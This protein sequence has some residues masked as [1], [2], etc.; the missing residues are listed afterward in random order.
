MKCPVVFIAP[1]LEAASAGTSA[2]LFR[3]PTSP[4]E[5]RAGIA[6]L[7]LLVAGLLFLDEFPD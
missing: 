7:T 1:P 4:G 3:Q 5:R 2:A 6:S